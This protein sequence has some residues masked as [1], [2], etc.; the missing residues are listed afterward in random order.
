MKLILASASPRRKELLASLDLAFTVDAQ[1]SFVENIPEG[2][3]V[4]EIPRY[5]SEGKSSGFHRPLEADELLITADTLVFLGDEAQGKPHD[6]E[7]A[8]R[9]LRELSGREHRVI[10]G[11]TLRS[12][13]SQESFIDIT[14]VRFAPLDE[15]DIAYYVD[16]YRPYDKA[17][18]YGIQE[19]IG[20]AAIEGIDGSYHN[21]MGLPTEKL[22][23]ALKRSGVV[24]TGGK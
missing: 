20:S 21:V 10:T 13:R 7:D 24:C 8:L 12:L 2:M 11:V 16:R 3:S 17:G 1:T 6:R 9:M 4:E 5:L 18:A 23:Q 22:F 15:Q 14:R 19:W